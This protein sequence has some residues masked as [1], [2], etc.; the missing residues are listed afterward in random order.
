MFT[1]PEQPGRVPLER[2]SPIRSGNASAIG[3]APPHLY[4]NYTG[5]LAASVTLVNRTERI[6][7]E[8]RCSPIDTMLVAT[9]SNSLENVSYVERTRF[10]ELVRN[11]SNWTAPAERV[12]LY[13]CSTAALIGALS[14]Q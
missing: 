8:C 1:K 5:E 9:E 6:F 3:E 10:W 2:Y 11:R 14:V 13:N 4:D 12:E 7:T